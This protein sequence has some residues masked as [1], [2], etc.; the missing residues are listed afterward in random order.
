MAEDEQEAADEHDRSEAELAE[1]WLE[2]EKMRREDGEWWLLAG[3][4]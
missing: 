2:I 4:N 3:V 1:M